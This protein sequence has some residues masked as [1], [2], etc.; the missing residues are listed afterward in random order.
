[1]ADIKQGWYFLEMVVLYQLSRRS[2]G[3]VKKM[4]DEVYNI[5]SLTS[6]DLTPSELAL[7]LLSPHIVQIRKHRNP[8]I[9]AR[10]R[11]DCISL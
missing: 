1:M 8:T 4:T 9:E 10:I 7:Q 5:T 3:L 6:F 2:D 11:G